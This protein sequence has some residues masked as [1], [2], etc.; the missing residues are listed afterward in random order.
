MN[1]LKELL[2]KY[3]KAYTLN[4]ENF[5]RNTGKGLWKVMVI[6][7]LLTMLCQIIEEEGN[8]I[9]ENDDEVTAGHN[10]IALLFEQTI[11]L[12]AQAFN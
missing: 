12:V 7:T 10:D 1:I 9:L 11:L 4:H 3:R 2:V 6:F 8:L 5:K